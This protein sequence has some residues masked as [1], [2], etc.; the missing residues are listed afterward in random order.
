MK[1]WEKEAKCKRTERAI[2]SEAL[3]T[4]HF[5][6]NS[7]LYAPPLD[8]PI[9]L[10]G[11]SLKSIHLFSYLSLSLFIPSSSSSSAPVHHLSNLHSLSSTSHFGPHPRFH[12]LPIFA[13]NSVPSSPWLNSSPELLTASATTSVTMFRIDGWKLVLSSLHFYV[14]FRPVQSYYFCFFRIRCTR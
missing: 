8:P 10:S 13:T 2:G 14:V 9:G 4:S 7:F 5:D 6:H 3:F 11:L 12:F 1:S